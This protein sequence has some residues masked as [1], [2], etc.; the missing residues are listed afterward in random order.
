MCQLRSTPCKKDVAHADQSQSTLIG[1]Q[2]GAGLA[3]APPEGRIANHST[4]GTV[5]AFYKQAIPAGLVARAIAFGI[6]QLAGVDINAI[7]LRPTHQVF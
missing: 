7:V 2:H 4:T 1:S 6:E 5:L 3:L